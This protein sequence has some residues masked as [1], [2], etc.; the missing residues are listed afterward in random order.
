MNGRNER[1]EILAD[2]SQY[3]KG[4]GPAR[5]VLLSKMGI[6][7]VEGLVLHYPR[8]YYD[9]TNLSRIC[10]IVPDQEGGFTGRVLAVSLR[11]LGPRRSI[12]TVAVGDET[13]IIDLVFFNQPYLEKQF[14][15]GETVIASGVAR[16]YRGKKQVVAPE[17]E[18]VS[19][20]LGD[21]LIHTG[22]IVPVYPLTAGISQRM[23]RRIVKSALEKS[24][25][26][27]RENLPA[28]ILRRL[29]LVTR[30]SAV[31]EIHY[32]S[33]WEELERATRR[34]KFEEVF[35]LHLLVLMRRKLL[36]GDRQ[37]PEVSP[38]HELMNRFISSLPF[39]MTSSQKKV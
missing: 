17:Y 39:D 2:S 9:R 3:V 33:G 18:T 8:K 13:G 1:T 16:I 27:V 32:P 35:F 22:R 14:K 21:E 30:E 7:T 10:D 15:Q 23:M 4:V 20:E 38:P 29:D 12:V 31:T 24:T 36:S 5:Q 19:G 34:L 6:D 37:R 11:K 25:G 28:R 26:Q